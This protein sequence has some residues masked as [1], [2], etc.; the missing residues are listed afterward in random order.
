ML[1]GKE[2]RAGM[3]AEPLTPAMT[4]QAMPNGSTTGVV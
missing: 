4:K 1:N 2:E 3:S